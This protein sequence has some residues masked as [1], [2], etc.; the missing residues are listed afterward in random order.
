MDNNYLEYCILGVRKSILNNSRTYCFLV[1]SFFWPGLMML[2]GC[3]IIFIIL[4]C[5][6][7]FKPM[8][9]A[10]SKV[11]YLLV[12]FILLYQHFQPIYLISLKL[13]QNYETH[14]LS[15]LSKLNF[16]TKLWA[17]GLLPW[18]FNHVICQAT[19]F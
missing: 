8:I 3:L 9:G 19:N 14:K 17:V 13:Y 11:R 4:F 6:A 2:T 12:G 1:Y 5:I 15:N 16:K 7:P 18:I 10:A